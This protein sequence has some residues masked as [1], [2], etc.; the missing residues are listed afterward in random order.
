M[1]IVGFLP[2]GI[3]GESAVEIAAGVANFLAVLALIRA[4]A[5][6]DT[7]NVRARVHAKRR[8]ELR[9][10]LLS[11]ARAAGRRQKSVS[12]LR[13]LLERLK[14]NRGEEVRNASDILA[15][16]GWR[17]PD[18][19]TVFLGMRLAMP[20]GLGILAYIMA[21]SIAPHISPL[22]RGLVGLIGIAAG[23]FAPSFFVKNATQKRRQKIQRGLP[24]ALD[25]FVICAE[26]GLSLDAAMTR[27][28]R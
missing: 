20:F 4:F 5:P 15:Q 16:A 9:A 17:T 26:A 12:A 27:V 21:P 11:P 10:T 1:S 19:L 2:S 24:D 22:V 18:A 14:L 7:V 23:S 13:G 28:A 6:N 8:R 25:L 3:S